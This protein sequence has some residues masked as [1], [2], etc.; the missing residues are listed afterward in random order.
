M[1]DTEISDMTELTTPA[2]GD[3]FPVV[4]TSDTTQ[5]AAGTNKY[6]DYDNLESTI[7]GSLPTM[8]PS[9]DTYVRLGTYDDS[10]SGILRPVPN[11]QLPVRRALSFN[12][13]GSVVS[14]T[15]ET[16]ILTAVTTIAANE[17]QE[18]TVVRV[19]M[20]GITKNDT[21]SGA[22]TLTIRAKMG[23]TTICTVTFTVPQ[24]AAAGNHWWNTE[25][26]FIWSD[27]VGLRAVG[28]Y[29]ANLSDEAAPANIESLTG[30]T[31]SSSTVDL[32]SSQDFDVTV[33][34][35]ISDADTA[36]TMLYGAMDISEET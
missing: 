5:D 18:N 21:A 28:I 6:V 33:Q 1:A 29:N 31:N 8:E 30:I 17:W 36:I 27:F 11:K 7:T 2:S 24:S 25:I 16:S 4:D 32:T 22:N 20:G 35:S 3:R 12:W 19:K 23:S 34:H 14:T 9:S 10:V 15:S 13:T 26:E